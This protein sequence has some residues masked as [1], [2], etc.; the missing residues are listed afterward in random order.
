MAVKK[1]K[2]TCCN[3]EQSISK[4]YM[5]SNDMFRSNEETRHCVCKECMWNKYNE[6]YEKYEDSRLSIYYAC[7]HYGYCFSESAV[8]GVLSQIENA[9]SKNKAIGNYFG[10]YLT[11]INSLKN[12]VGQDFYS[13]DPLFEKIE[14]DSVEVNG[15]V[16]LIGEPLI[17]K[18]DIVRILEYDPFDGYKIEDQKFLYPELVRYL[19]EDVQDDA[20]K[21]GVV[22]Q[23]ITNS[24]QIRWCDIAINKLGSNTDSFI[25]NSSI[26]K[27]LG[28]TKATLN[29]NNDKLSKE[30][31]IATKHRAGSGSKTNTLGSMMKDLRELGFEKAEMDYYTIQKSYGMKQS[32]DISNQSI[33]DIVKFDE[34]KQNEVFK[35][36]RDM[37]IKFQEEELELNERA[38]LLIIENNNLKRELKND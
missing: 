7:S 18:N 26:I 27:E 10:A 20:Y 37:I 14:V 16:E 23:I 21:V 11:K 17:C 35:L 38:R 2:C 25:E 8:Q 29:Q 5:S 4:F 36:Q 3:I 33:V 28:A 12:G 30:N 13:S 32:L 19:T 15:E 6:F 1:K 34:A 22:I 24:L 9:K 31:E